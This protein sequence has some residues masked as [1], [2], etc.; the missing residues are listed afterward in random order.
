MNRA[1]EAEQYVLGAIVMAGQQAYWRVADLIDADDFSSPVNRG[2][3]T[4]I[5][6]L[7]KSGAPIDFGTI[8]DKL[9]PVAADAIAFANATPSAA[10]I[11]A[12]AEIVAREAIARRVR[13]AGSQIAKLGGQDALGEAQRLLGVCMPKASS[14]VKHASEY[15]AQT[16]KVLEERCDA[17]EV[18]TGVPTSLEP[19]DELTSGWQRGD[20]ILIGARPS[21]GKT[22]LALQAAI[23]AATVGHNVLFLSLEMS[24]EQLT[25]RELAHIG[26]VDFQHIRQP[27]RLDEAEWARLTRA[28]E[29][30]KSLPLH[31]DESCALT[32]EALCARVRQM[33]ATKRIGLLVIDYLT[34]MTPPKADR[35]DIAWGMVTRALKQLAKE[36]KIPV[37][38]LC[39]LSRKG[40]HKPNLE[41]LRETGALE[42]DADLVL[43]LHRPDDQRRNLIECFLGKQRNG[44]VGDSIM[45]HAN[46]PHQR[47]ELTDEK[48]KS[49]PSIKLAEVA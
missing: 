42:Q 29:T 13:S 35:N 44:P 3:W 7:A 6:E 20:L 10:N 34:I 28:G 26:R 19:L 46:G 32:L 8:G 22:M 48:P 15:L 1:L 27:K 23:H 47:F 45:L 11:R 25:E 39:Q 16:V 31:I 2:M 30:I 41:D 4:A 24:G 37:M 18:L 38:L 21:I 49:A 14:A 40:V 43:F 36:L 17:E 33:D 5:M 12:Y 9:P